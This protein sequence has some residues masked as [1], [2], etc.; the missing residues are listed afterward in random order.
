MLVLRELEGGEWSMVRIR[1]MGERALANALPRLA[2][3]LG[4]AGALACSDDTGGGRVTE[5][6]AGAGSGGTAGAGG[7][8]GT[9]MAGDGGTG[10]VGNG[11]QGQGGNICFQG[12]FGVS[13]RA[14]GDGFDYPDGTTVTATFGLFMTQ[15]AS[16]SVRDGAFTVAF[17][18]HNAGC[19]LGASFPAPAALYIDVNGDGACTLADDEVFVWW[20]YAGPSSSYSTNGMAIPAEGRRLTPNGEHCMP[21]PLSEGNLIDETL[22][23]VRRLCPETAECLPFCSPPAPTA[24]SQPEDFGGYCPALVDAGVGPGTEGTD[25]GPD[26]GLDGSLDASAEADA[27]P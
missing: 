27:A 4:L 16:T 8:A 26:A 3:V 25:G 10:E 6:T 14:D 24:Y 23:A 15:T 22:A 2:A 18:E 13:T 21:M 1:R 9:G 5:G 19:N 12:T 7:T 20:E 17:V 11:G